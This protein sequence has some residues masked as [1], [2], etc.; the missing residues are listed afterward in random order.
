MTTDGSSIPDEGDVITR[1]RTYTTEDVREFG[2]LTGDQRS[3]HADPDEDGRVVVQGLLTGSLMTKIG[4]DLGYIARTV[5]FEFRKPVY[6]GESITCECTV[7]SKAE[8]DDRYHLEIDVN[9]RNESGA[10]VADART[11]GLIRKDE[12]R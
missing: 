11:T 4:G 7:D 2:A 12:S 5:D 3:I 6:T 8:R 10:V 1:E 9:F